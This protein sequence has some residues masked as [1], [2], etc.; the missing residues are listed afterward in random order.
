MGEVCSLAVPKLAFDDLEGELSAVRAASLCSSSSI[1]SSRTSRGICCALVAMPWY[2]SGDIV[3][4][5]SVRCIPSVPLAPLSSAL[6]DMSELFSVACVI[7]S[8]SA[9]RHRLVIW[10]G[11]V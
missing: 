8:S 1:L 6:H 5:I 3:E 10:R 4:L 2:V 7:A 11:V 9:A